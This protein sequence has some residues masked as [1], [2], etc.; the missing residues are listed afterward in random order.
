MSSPGGSGKAPAEIE[1]SANSAQALPCFEVVRRHDND[2]ELIVTCG[3]LNDFVI[4]SQRRTHDCIHGST[5]RLVLKRQRHAGE[6]DD[7]LQPAGVM[8]MR[9]MSRQVSRHVD[10]SAARDSN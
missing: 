1:F 5:G 9:T 6:Y 4:R 2:A 3:F 7:P 10:L 8:R